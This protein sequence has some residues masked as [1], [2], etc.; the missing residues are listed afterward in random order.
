MNMCDCIQGRPSCTCKIETMG[1]VKRYRFH[2]AAGEYVYA[3]IFDRVTAEREALQASL[4][5]RD[6]RADELEGLLRDARRYVESA[7]PDGV[8]SYRKNSLSGDL[9]RKI[10]AAINPTPKP[11]CCGS[12]GTDPKS[13]TLTPRSIRC[14]STGWYRVCGAEVEISSAAEC[15]GEGWIRFFPTV[16]GCTGGEL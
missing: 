2:G 11:T 4:T 12:C 1:K 9:L 5:V 10:D 7:W 13:S 15:P 8:H 3:P 14:G 16:V 6:Q